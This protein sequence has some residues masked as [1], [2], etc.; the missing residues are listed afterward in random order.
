MEATNNVDNININNIDNIIKNCSILLI[1]DDTWMQRLFIKFVNRIGI[2]NVYVA[3]NGFEGVNLA[4]EEKPDVIFLDI[5]MPDITGIQTLHMLK[6]INCT[7]HIPV[8]VVSTNSDFNNLG[9]AITA[10]ATGFIVKPFTYD[11]MVEKLEEIFKH[12]IESKAIHKILVKEFDDNS[13]SNADE[14][15]DGLDEF[16]FL[17][18]PEPDTENEN[19]N[20]NAKQEKKTSKKLDEALIK[21]YK[22]G[23]SENTNEIKKIINNNTQ[24]LIFLL[25]ID[26]LF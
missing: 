19:D 21:K 22:S 18:E 24:I 6:N 1:D 14:L 9:D 13:A 3:S 16:D 12:N 25:S 23:M 4:I 10:G 15:S 5:M 11:T 20:E 8:I 26:L 17:K 7:N 2:N